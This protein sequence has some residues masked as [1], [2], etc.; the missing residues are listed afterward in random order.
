[1]TQLAKC[2]PHVLDGFCQL[3]TNLDISE[4]GNHNSLPETG[5]QASRAEGHLPN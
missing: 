3:D 2:S 1:M 5:L 4:R